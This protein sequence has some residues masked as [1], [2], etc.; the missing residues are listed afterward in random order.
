MTHE[1]CQTHLFALQK[2]NRIISEEMDGRW[3][4]STVDLAVPAYQPEYSPEF[5]EM[6]IAASCREMIEIDPDEMIAQ[7]E[8]VIKN[9]WVKKSQF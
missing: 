3:V 6:I 7:L 4:V 2:G 8:V 1:Q 9:A 5:A